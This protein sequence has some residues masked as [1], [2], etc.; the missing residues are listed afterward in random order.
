MVH[1][2]FISPKMRS[3]LMD[4]NK[5]AIETTK[6]IIGTELYSDAFNFF[7]A[8]NDRNDDVI[9]FVT[10]K[11]HLMHKAANKC[12]FLFYNKIIYSDRIIDKP[13]PPEDSRFKDKRVVLVDDV[14]NSGSTISTLYERLAD[15]KNGYGCKSVSVFVFAR[16]IDYEL[17]DSISSVL[18][19]HL[20]MDT[21][22]V[23]A[24]AINEVRLVHELGM[25]YFLELPIYHAD[26]FTK[27]EYEDITRKLNGLKSSWTKEKYRVKLSSLSQ[28]AF[29]F[30]P[31]KKLSNVFPTLLEFVRFNAVRHLS[32]DNEERYSWNFV[33]IFISEYINND[34]AVTFL[35]RLSEELPNGK[36]L[37]N[38]LNGFTSSD[39]DDEI[40]VENIH[41]TVTY[42]LSYCIGLEFF[43]DLC[44]EKWKD[45]QVSREA[46]LSKDF[47]TFIDEF[48]ENDLP[49]VKRIINELKDTIEIRN[50]PDVPN[51]LNRKYVLNAIEGVSEEDSLR[52]NIEQ[53]LFECKNSRIKEPDKQHMAKVQIK[54]IVK[55]MSENAKNAYLRSA[56]MRMIETSVCSF[57]TVRH[58]LNGVVWIVKAFSPGENA[59]FAMYSKFPPK[60]F[61]ALNMFS[62][63]VGGYEKMI[64]HL[65]RFQ[66]ICVPVLEKIGER[67]ISVKEVVEKELSSKDLF[68]SYFLTGICDME[69]EDAYDSYCDSLAY[70]EGRKFRN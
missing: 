38:Y 6:S 66:E 49:T 59:F 68:N 24:F 47:I 65:D 35:T 21:N 7:T 62:L 1:F 41:R 44:L 46:H 42:I 70:E 53:L 5:W 15:E 25:V 31:K 67:K 26:F 17:P 27:D 58:K 14:I 4:I 34:F 51:E 13:C 29:L 22:Q 60:Y 33:P 64:P 2:E 50:F 18:D 40:F 43:A 8:L 30:V 11:A 52:M 56:I 45:Y 36:Y 28:E 12:G 55:A 9:I 61:N 20:L 10:R 39:W 3:R 57:S 19:S 23:R 32:E 16:N 48:S 63:G 37:R 69:S 54:D